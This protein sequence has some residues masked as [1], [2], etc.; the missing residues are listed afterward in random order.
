MLSPLFPENDNPTSIID[1]FHKRITQPAVSLAMNIALSTSKYYIEPRDGL[2]MYKDYREGDILYHTAFRFAELINA[3]TLKIV[4]PESAYPNPEDGRI[5]RELMVIRSAMWKLGTDDKGQQRQKLVA[6]AL[7]ISK[8]D[9]P[10]AR[11]APEAKSLMG[12][13]LGM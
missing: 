9:T 1:D 12:K 7:V 5:G 10:P 3:K 4:K 6:K 8:M 13:L 2:V 11:R